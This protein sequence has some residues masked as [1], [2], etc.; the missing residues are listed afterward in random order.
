VDANF[1]IK[2]INW[3]LEFDQGVTEFYMDAKLCHQITQLAIRY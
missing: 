1:A 2:P 3:Q